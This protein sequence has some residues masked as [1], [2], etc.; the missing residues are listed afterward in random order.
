[1]TCCRWRMR[2]CAVENCRTG[3][4][5]LTRHCRPK[6]PHG[7]RPPKLRF[8]FGTPAPR[9]LESALTFAESAKITGEIRQLYCR[10]CN[11]IAI[12]IE[13][14]ARQIR[15]DPCNSGR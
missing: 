14:T 3:N 10:E 11:E 4:F 2:R 13:P 9:T 1:M 7:G 6:L 8:I 12:G 15:N 5:H